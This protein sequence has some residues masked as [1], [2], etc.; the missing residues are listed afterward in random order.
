MREDEKTGLRAEEINPA[1][2]V[3]PVSYTHLKKLEKE[4][5]S[6]DEIKKLSEE[7]QK[8]TDKYVKEID[9]TVEEKSKEVLTV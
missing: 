7:I 4:D 3:D 1:D 2:R 8:L 5:V 6:E 9:K